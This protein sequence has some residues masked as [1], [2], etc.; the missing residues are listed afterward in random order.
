M[1]HGAEPAVSGAGW[2]HDQKGCCSG[3]KAFPLVGAACFLTHRMNL[4][5][6]QKGP[7]TFVVRTRRKPAP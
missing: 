1:I 2:P 3:G 7:D 4:A 6:L 5:A